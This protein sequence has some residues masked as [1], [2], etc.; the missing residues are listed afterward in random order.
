MS[1]DGDSDAATLPV[2]T[3]T[4]VFRFREDDGRERRAHLNYS[5]IFRRCL[6][7]ADIISSTPSPVDY[8]DVVTDMQ[9]LAHKHT[10]AI[11]DVPLLH[12]VITNIIIYN[13]WMSKL[14]YWWVILMMDSRVFKGSGNVNTWIRREFKTRT[15]NEKL[16]SVSRMI[17]DQKLD[18]KKINA[19]LVIG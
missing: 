19:W 10:W 8:D 18:K 14:Q 3:L 12:I 16:I 13:K 15:R 17:T 1:F 7:S 5:R 11:I 6:F 9:H 2:T 4:S